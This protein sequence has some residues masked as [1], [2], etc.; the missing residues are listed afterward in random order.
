MLTLH[1]KCIC[2]IVAFLFNSLMRFVYVLLQCD[3]YTRAHIGIVN[4]KTARET[5]PSVFAFTIMHSW[6]IYIRA[7]TLSTAQLILMDR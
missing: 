4:A 2:P 3:V 6:Y 7:F 1:F 5:L